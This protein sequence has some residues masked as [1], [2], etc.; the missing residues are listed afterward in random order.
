MRCLV[1]VIYDSL[2]S[3][4]FRVNTSCL[5]HSLKVKSELGLDVLLKARGD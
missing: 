5:N 1:G 4:R 3:F 2:E